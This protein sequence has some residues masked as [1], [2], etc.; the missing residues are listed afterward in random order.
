MYFIIIFFLLNSFK[1]LRLIFYLFVEPCRWIFVPQE[2]QKF[3][4]LRFQWAYS[5]QV[6]SKTAAVQVVKFSICITRAEQM[7][8]T[9]SYWDNPVIRKII[10][11]PTATVNAHHRQ[12]KG[13]ILRAV[14]RKYSTNCTAYKIN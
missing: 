8:D 14:P 11:Q 9:K 5:L 12:L 4:H 1:L 13:R 10:H 6:V 7:T 3:T 2:N